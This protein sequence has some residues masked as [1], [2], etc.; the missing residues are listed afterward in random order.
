MGDNQNVLKK[1]HLRGPRDRQGTVYT[2]LGGSIGGKAPET[3]R[4]E[5]SIV[6]TAAI[7]AVC[8]S[9]HVFLFFQFFLS[10]VPL[11][12]FK[13]APTFLHC[14]S[15]ICIFSA[16][17]QEIRDRTPLS[18][19]IGFARNILSAKRNSVRLE[20]RKIWKIQN[21]RLFAFIGLT[22]ELEQA[23][24]VMGLS[25]NTRVTCSTRWIKAA[26][27]LDRVWKSVLTRGWDWPLISS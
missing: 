5:H 4:S 26:L 19:S 15:V 21:M 17:N 27:W 3:S 1:V 9:M 25:F 10:K 14:L 11:L 13:S 7:R 2:A 16:A 8:I 12:H 24:L 20:E 22:V 18:W 6:W 23:P